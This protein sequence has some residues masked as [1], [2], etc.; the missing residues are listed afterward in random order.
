MKTI[1]LFS[2]CLLGMAG[3]HAQVDARLFQ[4]P[5]V[6]Q[7]QITFVYG[8]DI[9]VAPKEGGIASRLSSPE[10]LESFPRFSPDGSR[11]AFSGNYDGNVDIYVLPSQGGLPTRVTH[12]GM[13][14]RLVDWYPD[15]K[16]LLYAASMESGK[17]RWSQLYKISPEGGLPEKL[18]I[19]HAEMGALS[20]DSKKIAFTDRSQVFRTWKR[21]RGGSAPDIWIFDLQTMEAQNFTRNTANDELPMWTGDKIYYLS[22]QGP[23]IRFNI[24][25]YDTK[26]KTSKQV[27]KFK[28]FDVHFPSLGPSEIVFEADGKLYLLGLKD[29]KYKEVQIQVVTDQAFV[30]PRKESVEKFLQNIS[31]SPDGNR[32][33]VEARGELF[34]VPA[35]KGYVQNL[36]QSPGA[37]ERYPAWSPDGKYIAYW[38]D[39]SGEYELTV[40]DLSNGNKEKQLTQLGPGFRYNLYWSPDSKKLAFVDQ[41][42][43]MRIYHME[44]NTLDRV[45]QDFF[46][47]EGGLRGWTPSWSPDSRWLAY[48]R[49]VDNSNNALFIYDSKDKKSKQASSGFY[50][51]LNPVFDPEGKYLYLTTNRSFS[52]VYSDFD[53]SWIYPNA[54]QLAAI[55]LRKDVPSLLAAEN[56]TVA[57]QIDTIGNWKKSQEE[58][59]EEAK[60]KPVEIDFEGFEQRLVILPPA[61]GNMG[62]LYPTEGKLVFMR[63]PVAGTP[64]PSG[65]L[66]YYDLKEREEKTILENVN[67]HKMSAD[68]KKLLVNS[69]GQWGVVEPNPD[70]KLEKTMPVAEMEATINPREEWR[71]IFNDTWRFERDFFYDEKM[72]GVDWPAMRKQY[73]ALIEHASS[74]NDVNFIIGELIG[75]LNA[76]HTYRGGGDQETTKSRQVGY[77]GVNWEKVDGHFRI[78]EIIR[79]AAWD[80]EVRSPLDE[81]GIGV[82]AGDFVLAVNGIALK[83]YTDPWAAFEGLAGKTVELTVHSKASM[84]GAR[85]VVVQ[86][87]SDETRLRNLAWIESNRRHVDEASGGKLGYIY[88]PSTGID[89]QNELVR[90]FYGQWNKEGLVIDERFNNGGQIPD[91][92]IELLNRKPLAYWDVRDGKTWQWPPVANFGSMAMLINGWSGSGGD[93]FPDYFRKSGLGPLIGSRTWGGL[94]GISGSPSLIDGGGVTVPTFRMYNP[95]GTWFKEGH[96]VDP[97]IEVPED[98]SALAKGKDPQ[99]E[100]AIEVVMKQLAAKGTV[101]PKE[102]VREDRTK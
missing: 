63:F 97:D 96:G 60:V 62:G 53:N 77:L 20:P 7:T 64:N 83:D 38:S 14:D 9:W 54:T 101:K 41:T 5:D 23:E 47:F 100:K 73:G 4:F 44:S 72:H 56:D 90:Q 1:I 61:A 78:K 75:E 59:K 13:F 45:D 3:L 74:R 65:T 26:A 102:P 12:H 98:P 11:I 81:P 34:S 8:D 91:R 80:N 39:K 32:A 15:G 10:G 33:V 40:R 51:D 22:D 27:T 18:P 70:Q 50:N 58:K 28:D 31:I 29:E 86:T 21:Y 76:S 94:I 43:T 82:Q 17:Q 42:M 95:D 66:M 68:G 35:V 93:A 52:P 48:S 57:I 92:F 19:V 25:V 37:A 6:S 30:K 87:L 2:F 67:W 49:T 99:L 89:G 16:H 71:Q 88:V 24:W 79:G 84:E 55:S 36:S 46:L 69:N 85:T